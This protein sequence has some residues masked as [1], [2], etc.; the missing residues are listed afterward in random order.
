MSTP[1]DQPLQPSLAPKRR[2]R[3]TSGGDQTPEEIARKQ[4]ADAF[5]KGKKHRRESSASKYYIGDHLGM[6]EDN[7]VDQIL[8]S[9]SPPEDLYFADHC[10]RLTN[11]NHM[12]DC[13]FIVTTNHICITNTRLNAYIIPNPIPISDIKS[14]STSLETDNAVVIHLPEYNSELIMTS[15]KIELMKVLMDRFKAITNRELEIKFSNVL[16][17]DVDDSTSFEFDFVRANDGVRMTLF[18]KAKTARPP[19]TH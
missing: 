2:E 4:A 10:T 13:G 11:R 15:F 1:S 14:I 7:V 16:E 18:I 9:F 19:A 12:E 8:F 17:F 6:H 3:L 5:F